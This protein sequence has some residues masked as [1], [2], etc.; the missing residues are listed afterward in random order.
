MLTDLRL[1][2]YLQG[3]LS[4]EDAKEV[5][6]L[7]SKNPDMQARLE[8][9]KN[10]SEI[11]GRPMWQRVLLDRKTRHGGSRTRTTILL[12]LLIVVAVI[13]LLGGHWFS[14][15]GTNSTFTMAGGNGTALELL[16]NSSTGW[17]Y[18]DAGFRGGD[19]LT[20]SIRDSGRYHVAVHAIFGSGREAEVVPIFQGGPE[21]RFGKEGEKPVFVAGKADDA[22]R[23]AQILVFYDDTPLPDLSAARVLDILETK[24][25]ERGGMDFRY[26]IFSSGP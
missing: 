3:L 25:N 10:Q 12:P 13:L 21:K 2:K 19:S 16:Y 4:E 6:A 24:G 14:K 8:A 17:R 1:Q 20:F 7:V 15:P 22:P 23:P 18:L 26:Q 11:V 9:L 5:E